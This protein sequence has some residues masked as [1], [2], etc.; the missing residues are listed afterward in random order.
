MKLIL[1]KTF[2]WV[3]KMFVVLLSFG[4]M[5]KNT[6]ACNFHNGRSFTCWEILLISRLSIDSDIWSQYRW[7]LQVFASVPNGLLL[8]CIQIELSETS[9]VFPGG[10]TLECIQTPTHQW[11]GSCLQKSRHWER[12]GKSEC[13]TR[14]Q[15]VWS[16][17]CVSNRQSRCLDFVPCS[18]E[19]TGE[20][21]DRQF[22]ATIESPHLFWF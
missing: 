21:R 18:W 20:V 22:G 3:S 8:L 16:L 6:T 13:L 12:A 7:T 1:L 15:P 14:M 17:S 2:P 9:Q 10:Q 11:K 19:A 5:L 4:K